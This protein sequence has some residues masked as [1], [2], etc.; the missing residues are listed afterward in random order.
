MK[1]IKEVLEF[2]QE[3]GV[4]FLQINNAPKQASKQINQKSSLAKINEEIYLCQKCPLFKTKNNYVPGEGRIN[5]DIMFIGEGPGGDEDRLGKP[6]VG[7]AGKLLDR[8]LEKT[9]NSRKEFFIGNIV[10]C[11]P[12]GN[13]NPKS[14]EIK[15]CMGFLLRQ[16]KVIKPKVIV[17]LGKIAM[18]NLLNK[19]QSIM[20][21]HG[22]IFDFNGIPLVPTIHPSYI[23]HQ[24]SLGKE[25]VSKSK[26]II[27][28][29]IQVAMSIAKTK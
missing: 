9:G 6:F 15:A 22:K 25:A 3:I 23:L 24:S 20:K 16:I 14:D 18:N 13:R 10:K 17:C 28:N 21:N 1:K 5:P 12:P 7:K 19:D 8:L 11:R 2:Y 4:E 29:D 27:W 26:W